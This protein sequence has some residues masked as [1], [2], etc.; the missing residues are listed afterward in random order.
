MYPLGRPNPFKEEDFG[1]TNAI[2]R[3]SSIKKNEKQLDKT[4]PF[5]L[6]LDL[7]DPTV[8]G[9]PI[10]SEQLAPL[11]T[12]NN[13]GNVGTGALW[14]ALYGCKNDPMIEMQHGDYQIVSMLH[15]G[16][17]AQSEQVSA[18]IYSM[19]HA[20]VLME[21]PNPTLRIPAK[22]R[23]SLLKL[24]FFKL[25]RSVCEWEADIIASCIEVEKKVVAATAKA[26]VDANP[27]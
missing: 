23:A 6:W 3:I 17:F 22:F 26:L 18:V 20:T 25:D 21:H 12:E 16:K 15:H 10:S 5:V 19:P 14:F 24:P 27:K 11:Y 7:Q 2:S 4:K 1:L 9:L 8:W 13:G